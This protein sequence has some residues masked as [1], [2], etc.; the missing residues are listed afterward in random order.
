MLRKFL[1]LAERAVSATSTRSTC[2]VQQTLATRANVQQCRP[3]ENGHGIV[4]TDL[5]TKPHRVE[6]NCVSLGT[7]SFTPNTAAFH[8]VRPC[9]WLVHFPSLFSFFSFS[10]YL[11]FTVCRSCSLSQNPET[12]RHAWRV[13]GCRLHS[14]F[15]ILRLDGGDVSWRPSLEKLA[16]RSV[17]MTSPG[18]G[19]E[20]CGWH[21]TGK[22]R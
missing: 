20:G 8:P 11:N 2:Y 6:Q 5:S 9:T 12:R 15:L 3:R 17:S 14:T 18:C 22:T 13:L 10:F 21:P 4:Y 7:D 16:Q 19:G 1:T